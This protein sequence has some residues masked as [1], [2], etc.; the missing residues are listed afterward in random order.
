MKPI[1]SGGHLPQA[2]VFILLF[3]MV[4]LFSDMTH[5][6]AASIRGAYLS[7]LGASAGVIGFI[8]GLGELTGYSL[9]YLFGRWADRTKQYWTMTIGGYV[10]DVIAV[11]ALALVGENGWIAA[12]GL[13]LF[14]RLGKAVK[15]PAKDTLMSFAA[16]QT[17]TGKSFG[18]QELLDQIGAFL[19]PVL[20]YLVMLNRA[21]EDLFHT[22]ALCFAVLAVPGAI[23]LFLLFATKRRFPHPE[24]FEPEPKEY[25]PF[26]M[27]KEFILYIAGISL[28]AFGFIDYSLVLMHISR[29]FTSLVPDLP[30]PWGVIT[31]STLPLLYAGAML[32]DAAAAL[33]FGYLYDRKGVQVLILSAVLS[34]PFAYFIF[35]GETVSSILL[36][37]ALWGIG[38]GAQESILKAAV[39]ALVPKNSRATGYGIFECSFGIFW[40]LGSWLLG[41]LY[42]ISIPAMIAVSVIAQL[43]AVPFYL[44]SARCR[45]IR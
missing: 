22:Y 14:Q 35:C 13:L 29:T 24:Q 7:L 31:E 21:E 12:C 39:T 3:G 42:D 26:R 36:G 17:G 45:E 1:S 15:K 2:M 30:Q 5:E 10:L 20:L 38:M 32:A 18:I 6:G 33:V 25:I 16:S 41:V 43:A 19:G 40:F 27:K 37:I 11:P 44:G 9:R 23:T 4:S 28:F 34:A 8:S